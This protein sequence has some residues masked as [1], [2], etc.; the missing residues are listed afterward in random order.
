MAHKEKQKSFLE[1]NIHLVVIAVVALV[2]GAVYLNKSDG[3]ANASTST[4]GVPSQSVPSATPDDG[5]T[6]PD[7]TLMSSDGKQVSLSDYKGKVV[8]VDFW[9]TWCPPCKAE[10]PDFIK[11]YSQY[12]NDGFQMLGIS[13]DQGGL[14][15]VVPFMK[16][17][18]VN[19]P[20]LLASDQVVSAYGGIQ[21][22][23]TTFVIDKHG[24]VRAAFEGYRPASVFEDLVQKLL[25]EK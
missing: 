23:P 10:I 5:K 21:G 2:V 18:G 11:L 25:K 12:K 8:V 20:I 17:Y 14:K 24:K 22:I 16:Q 13:V 9:A 3:T 19:Y 4:T 6:A 7:F 1:K 15:A